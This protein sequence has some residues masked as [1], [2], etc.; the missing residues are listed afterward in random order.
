MSSD[1][2]LAAVLVANGTAAL[3]G[4]IKY[5]GDSGLGDSS[6]TLLVHQFLQIWC[7]HLLHIG[8]SHHEADGIQYVWFPGAVK[9]RY[10]VEKLIEIGHHR[11]YGRGLE[12][13]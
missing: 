5:N 10:G 13:L 11:S 4:V 1:G 8:D 3:I 7:H 2:D 12:T 9:P 6:L